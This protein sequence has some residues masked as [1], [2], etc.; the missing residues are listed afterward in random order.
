MNS[1]NNSLFYLES[2]KE[3]DSKYDLKLYKSK[4]KFKINH[5]EKFRPKI[6][7]NKE[8]NKKSLKGAENQ[9]KKILSDF[10]RTYESEI[11]E[12]D[13][14]FK[15]ADSIKNINSLDKDLIKKKKIKK[16]RTAE[17]KKLR[18][19]N[20]NKINFISIGKDNT[21]NNYSPLSKVFSDKK[22][23]KMI[24]NYSPYIQKKQYSP[25]V[26]KKVKFLE[27]EKN[28][29][30]QN[31]K[32]PLDDNKIIKDKLQRFYSY[33]FQKIQK[34][35]SN[36]TKFYEL[37]KK[38]PIKKMRT[39]KQNKNHV[40]FV[41]DE[42][43]SNNNNES[44]KIKNKYF[45]NINLDNIKTNNRKLSIPNKDQIHLSKKH[46]LSFSRIDI[47]SESK[48]LNIIPEE[49]NN[50]SKMDNFEKYNRSDIDKENSNKNIQFENKKK[51]LK[52]IL[53]F[54]SIQHKIKKNLILRPEE[55]NVDR[56]KEINK[57]SP[58]KLKSASSRLK[59]V[60]IGGILKINKNFPNTNIIGYYHN[61]QNEVLG[62]N[63]E[64]ILM[65]NEKEIKPIIDKKPIQKSESSNEDYSSYSI[66]RKSNI[67]S[68]KYRKI[69]HKGVIYD[70]LD[71]EEFEDVEEINRLYIDPNS[72][73]C[74]CFDLILFFINIFTFVEIPL[75]IAIN[76]NFCRTQRF[77]YNDIL[78]MFNEIINILDFLFGFFRAYYNMEEQLIKKKGF[79]I[80]KYLIGW[81]LFD[82]ISAIPVYSLIK[83]F[84][85]L[86]DGNSNS[87]YHNYLL[88]NL[89]YLF[90]CNRI[91][92]LVK[93]IS[94]NQGWKYISI[95]LTDFWRITF[96]ICL[97]I[98]ALNYT[99]CLYIF[100]ARNS[101]PNWIL[102]AGLDIYEF[103]YIYICAIYA[104][105]VTL[106][107]VGYGDITCCSLKE[108]VFQVFLLIIGIIAYSW[109]ISSFSN[110][111]Q[112]INEKSVEYEKKKSILDEIKFNNPNLSDSL[113][114]KIL[115]YIKFRHFH[116][117]NVK[118][119]IFDCLPV[120]LKNNLIYEM[121]KPIIKNFILFKNFQN[122][123]FIVQVITCF[124]PILAYKNYILVNE[125]DL[126]ED[127]IFVKH[128]VLSVELP[129]NATNL[130]ENIDKYLTTN[131]SNKD[132]EKLKNTLTNIKNDAF[133][134]FIAETPN[135]LNSLV[136]NSIINSSHHYKTTFLTKTNLIKVNQ[137]KDEKVN[138]KILCI[139][140]NE[141]FGDVLMFLE[142]RSPLQVR[143]RSKKCELFFLKKIDALKIS[144]SYPHIWRRINKKSVYNFKQIKKYIRKIVEIYCSVKENKE[145]TEENGVGDEFGLEKSDI[146]VH[147]QNYDSDNSA[148][149]SNNNKNINKNINNSDGEIWERTKNFFSKK[150][151]FNDKYFKNNRNIIQK[152]CHSIKLLKTDFEAL[153]YQ[154][155]KLSFSDSSSYSDL[156]PKNKPK[157]KIK[158]N[159]NILKKEFNNKSSNIINDKYYRDI[160]KQNNDNNQ[161]SI[162]HEES[163]RDELSSKKMNS[164]NNDSISKNSINSKN[165]IIEKQSI[166]STIKNE[167]KINIK[168]KNTNKNDKQK[169]FSLPNIDINNNYET[170]K[171]R[172][173]LENTSKDINSLSNNEYKVNN[174]I[175]TDE[176]LEINHEENLLNKKLNTNDNKIY[177]IKNFFNININTEQ[178]K[179]NNELTKLLK[180]F[181]E[182]SK[183]YHKNI[184]QKESLCNKTSRNIS[185]R[186]M[187]SNRV[188]LHQE[189][190]SSNDTSKNY[191]Y[192]NIKT[193][194]DNNLFS[195]DN[196][197]SLN[198]NSSYDNYNIISGEKLIKSKSLQNKLKEYLIKETINISNDINLNIENSSIKKNKT[199]D[200]NK[201][202]N[203]VTILNTLTKKK[204]TSSILL[205]NIKNYSTNISFLKNKYKK[206]RRSI[207]SHDLNNLLNV[208][209]NIENSS[210]NYTSLNIKYIKYNNRFKNK[211][212]TKKNHKSFVKSSEYSNNSNIYRNKSFCRF[213]NSIS[214]R[215][216][217]YKT[218][219]EISKKPRMK[220][221]STVLIS[222]NSSKDKKKRKDSLLE[223]IG[224]NIKKT[225]QKLNEPKIFYNNYFNNILKEEMKEKHKKH[226]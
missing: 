34:P 183:S 190:D 2:N 181:E 57:N 109:L 50:F 18:Y 157:K 39:I 207:S 49:S 104:L 122:I 7:I 20:Q 209:T 11:N 14:S 107:T 41:E 167:T 120:G 142:E 108:R 221:K 55:T 69:L 198:I 153:F 17:Y 4:D 78:N 172:E 113:Y 38:S 71:D 212:G 148:L 19:E 202:H 136:Y 114:D 199:S 70:S 217:K 60:V 121:Y 59:N 208:D 56:K 166:N 8:I 44:E 92:K 37:S 12:P 225:N 192:S 74:I 25:Q 173:I 171:N 201:K 128:G 35:N 16:I 83:I 223:L 30:I 132:K 75:Y 27:K 200:I 82:L 72:Y 159:K 187:K 36:R 210:K 100:I 32:M 188:I 144:T 10:L 165:K 24:F 143:V 94:N 68:E 158:W 90:L 106:T 205:N 93:I 118:N 13:I 77:T 219:K 155:N 87:V 216:S 3:D 111:I 177:D 140:D 40:N 196:N 99:A 43:I 131:N 164:E 179:G 127:I 222:S 86:C 133:S 186:T 161:I 28:N 123:D 47:K 213:D 211:L 63:S 98:F 52:L 178:N 130:Q 29:E 96:N 134:S 145:I 203:K 102:H 162:I 156:K 88:D 139:R 65:N 116:V 147:P 67:I 62:N 9:I 46:K 197:I 15:Q 215:R 160:N 163:N 51:F 206:L 176:K 22:L 175:N 220:R 214:P 218:I 152:K 95:K 89:Y 226:H 141:H 151:G 224:N 191:L 81:C 125:G 64:K 91:F 119:T 103:K 135:K 184:P 168:K 169:L 149:N 48:N 146:W 180:Y 115:K 137:T 112:K 126:I 193:Y 189:I 101:Y 6:K 79:I 97:I 31:I 76:L 105:I 174:E 5:F 21:K 80:K 154:E 182:E 66:K 23:N 170:I 85:P 58:K 138:V 61:V 54:K 185:K 1:R 204:M 129:L 73:F 42:I 45:S 53:D 150:Y 26:W 33:K 124:K 110:L 84:E 117:K 194:W 195:I